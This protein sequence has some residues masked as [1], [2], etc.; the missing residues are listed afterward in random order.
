M[1]KKNIEYGSMENGFY[2]KVKMD[3]FNTVILN[4]NEEVYLSGV[5]AISTL[6]GAEYRWQLNE[7]L[8][9]DTL[10]KIKKEVTQD[11][12]DRRKL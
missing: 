9:K 6:G 10:N 4:N 2:E 1:T 11:F 12:N 5:I 7:Y 8:S 3:K